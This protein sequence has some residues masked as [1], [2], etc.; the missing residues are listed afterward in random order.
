LR[1]ELQRTEP[2]L[3]PGLHHRAAAWFRGQGSTDDAVR[4]LVAA[5]D[6][7]GSME[8]IAA[9]WAVEFNRGRLSTVSRWL[10]LL[11]ERTVTED[12]RL[13]VART[14]IAL[15]RGQL[16]DAGR[17]IE[18]A[19]TGLTAGYAAPGSIEAEIAVLR[20]VQRFKIG[21]VAEA[22]EVARRAIHLG[23]GDSPLGRSAAYCVYGAALYRSGR[24]PEALAAFRRA[25]QLA[26]E[27]DNHLG[28]TYALGY[29]AMISVD[30]G[31]L[32]EAEQLIRDATGEDRDVAV[33]EHFVNMMPSLATAK[34]LHR[35]DEIALAE[36]AARRAVVLSQRGGGNLEMA[37]ALLTR[38]KIL[39]HLGDQETA[40]TSVQQARTVLRHCRGPGAAQQ[41]R[42][43]AV[44]GASRRRDR[45]AYA[46]ELTTKELDVLRLLATPLSRREIGSRL[47]VSLNTV[48]TH[49]RALYR[50]LD[51]TNR[52]MAVERARDLGLL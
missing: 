41:L 3:V 43:T 5:G 9:S 36:D 10:D 12:P 39:Q 24:T 37:H 17:W 16:Q 35:R 26:E 32:A 7:P 19:K 45:P 18:T 51:V 34:I 27:V 50:K 52:T 21:D 44:E 29:L 46:E 48:K 42:A 20:A 1:N 38:A 28:R 33:G 47:Y 25:V 30:S 23:L 6:V 2:D 13:C 49:Q 40:A 15:D 4:H 8:L 14:W 31:Q 22:V 11:P